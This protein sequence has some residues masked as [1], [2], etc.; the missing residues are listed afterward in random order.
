MDLAVLIVVS[1]TMGFGYAPVVAF[2]AQKIT[3]L[4]DVMAVMGH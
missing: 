2:I 1:A 3:Y 4:A